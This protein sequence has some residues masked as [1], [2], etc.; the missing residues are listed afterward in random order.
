VT[1]DDFFNVDAAGRRLRAKR[2]GR[3]KRTTPTLVLLH[4]GLGSI[5]QWRDFPDAL[6]EACGLPAL[7]YERHGHGGSEPID[8]P[9]PSNF[10]EIEALQ[11]LPDVLAACEIERPFLVGHSDGGTIAL[12]YAAAFPGTPIGCITEAAHV[13]FETVTRA[14]VSAVSARWESDPNFRRRLSQYHSDAEGLL[15]TWADAWLRPGMLSWT[16]TEQL[17]RIRCP[18]LAIQGENDEHGTQ[19]Q[20]SEIAAHV[21]GPVETVMIPNCG[22][23]PHHEARTRVLA[24]MQRFIAGGAD[25]QAPGARP[26]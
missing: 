9:R 11:A 2:I 19:A 18:V 20:V 23:V 17:A 24:E 25:G 26:G 13:M 8:L 5:P 7:I 22:H 14:G 3:W 4:E 1:S 6:A 10:L 12:L 16:I 15:R 21:S